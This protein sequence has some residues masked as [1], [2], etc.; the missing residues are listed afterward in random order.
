V[1]VRPTTFSPDPDDAARPKLSRPLG[2]G[3]MAV[4]AIDAPANYIYAPAEDLRADMKAEDAAIWAKALENTRRHLTKRPR[5]PAMGRP[6]TF[7]TGEGMASSLLFEDAFWDSPE[8]TAAGPLV[9][10]PMG[11]DFL[12]L[13]LQ[14]DAGRWRRCEKFS[15]VKTLILRS[16]PTS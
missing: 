5:P 1:L 12:M 16:W 13:A 9:V 11:K 14:S 15:R 7:T 3:L 10:S 6:V 2:A 8:M 4:V